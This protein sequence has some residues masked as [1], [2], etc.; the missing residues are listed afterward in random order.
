MK[1]ERQEQILKILNE[2]E[3]ATVNTLADTLYVS[4]PTVR[5]DLT[6]LAKKGLIRRSHGGAAAVNDKRLAVPFDFRTG[7]GRDIKV[8]M[9]RAAAALV[10]D[11]DTV[12][13]D[14]STSC[15]QIAGF[16]KERCGITLVT[17]SAHLA[18]ALCGTGFDIH[19][20]GGRLIESSLSFVG[21]RAAQYAEDFHFDLMFFSSAAVSDSGIITD[22]SQPETELRRRVFR[23]ADRKIMLC[24]SSKFQKSAAYFVL[25]AQELNLL[26]TDTAPGF[27]QTKILVV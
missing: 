22:Y 18:G 16:L 10:S 19:C 6:E 8:R 25:N 2:K 9:S 23:C 11:G 21:S 7:S 26:I 13:I 4:L 27:E 3:F 20:T 15:M 14:G 12:F 24:D 1:N 5:R 17:N